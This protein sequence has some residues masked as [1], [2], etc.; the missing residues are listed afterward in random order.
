MYKQRLFSFCHLL[1][2]GVV[3]SNQ[4]SPNIFP[5][6]FMF[7]GTLSIVTDLVYVLVM[8]EAAARTSHVGCVYIL[9]AGSL[10]RTYQRII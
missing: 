2:S 10:K 3:C 9:V 8:V 5:L 7:C 6:N 4:T 1:L